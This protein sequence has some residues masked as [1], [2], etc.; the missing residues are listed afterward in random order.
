MFHGKVVGWGKRS[1]ENVQIMS[2]ND[3][4]FC[5]SQKEVVKGTG[6]FFFRYSVSSSLFFFLFYFFVVVRGIWKHCNRVKG[7]SSHDRNVS[8]FFILFY[9]P[10][11]SSCGN[12]CRWM[13]V[14]GRLKCCENEWRVRIYP[15][16][17]EFRTMGTMNGKG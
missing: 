16:S 2:N 11:I 1:G 17:S 9:F 14:D 12:S 5:Y 7:C 15:V 3:C 8:I 4:K 13:R 6:E 10:R